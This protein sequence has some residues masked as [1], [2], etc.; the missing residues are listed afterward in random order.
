MPSASACPRCAA[1]WDGAA[2]FCTACGQSMF[3][4]QAPA[5]QPQYYA[6][7]CS[8]CGGG[9][10][11]LAADKVYCPTCRWL[12]PLGPGYDMPVDAFMW[13][14][15]ADA[16]NTLRGIGPLNSAAHSL[17]ETVGRPW[18]EA[19]VNGIRLSEQQMPDIFA[20]AI[21]A[22]RIVGLTHLPEIYISGE[23]MWDAVTMGSQTS[24]FIAIG[25]VLTNFRGDD[26][27]YLLGREMG[28]AKAGHALWNTVVNLL[29]GRQP[30]N[31]SLMGDG[32]LSF[33]NPAKLIESG[34]NAPLMAWQRH[35][36]I[37]ADRAGLLCV[38]DIAVARRVTLQWTL[39]SFPLA[40]RIN[41]E[42]W[43][44]QEDAADD[45]TVATSEFAMTSTPYAARR[46]KLA[47]E[48]AES[49]EFSGWRRVIEHWAPRAGTEAKPVAAAPAQPKG[50]P[51]AE[52]E[53]LM[54]IACK[55]P[56]RVPKADLAGPGPVNVR[57]P[58]PACGKVIKITPKQPKPP[59]PDQASE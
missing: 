10:A 50:P 8:T 15:D 44:V 46:L 48:F 51:P 37:T 52:T 18:F 19:A 25:S 56:M 3:G 30:G 12:R 20:L 7:A 53:R 29:A 55:S 58:N 16:M 35:S 36:A 21:R 24:S 41:A 14:L 47:R 23:H 49:A 54:C 57:C 34:I 33:L 27:L 28:H 1:A 5:P 11:T 31:R 38:G 40:Q 6:Y 13:R 9:G 59:R 45:Q 4:A 17:S 39:H 32:M 42:A 2:R 26:L 22:A 43:K